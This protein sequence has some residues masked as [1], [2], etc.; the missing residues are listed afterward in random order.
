MVKDYNAI[1]MFQA[2]IRSESL[3]DQTLGFML[4]GAALARFLCSATEKDILDRI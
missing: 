4:D 2:T 1:G 3:F